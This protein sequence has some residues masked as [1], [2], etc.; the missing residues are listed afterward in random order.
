MGYQCLSQSLDGGVRH[1][2]NQVQSG[3]GHRSRQ[4]SG[5]GQ[6]RDLVVLVGVQFDSAEDVAKQRTQRS[7]A[8]HDELHDEVA[9]AGDQVA[10]GIGSVNA[11]VNPAGH[12]VSGQRT[13]R[14]SA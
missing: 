8:A 3:D 11:R 14:Q 10:I 12:A 4:I 7:D 6:N 2:I 9:D 5:D 13:R 1:K